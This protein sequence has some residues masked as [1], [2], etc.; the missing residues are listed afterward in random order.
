METAYH[1]EGGMGVVRGYWP[2][3]PAAA[4]GD[5]VGGAAVVETCL[6]CPSCALGGIWGPSHLLI[7]CPW[8]RTEACPYLD[9]SHNVNVKGVGVA[10][11]QPSCSVG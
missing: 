11:A 3:W 4:D 5:V 10:V 1:E 8:S 7:P 2:S 9:A 6:S